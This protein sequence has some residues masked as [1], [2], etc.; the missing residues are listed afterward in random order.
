MITSDLEKA[1]R[2]AANIKSIYSHSNFKEEEI[3]KDLKE[4]DESIGDPTAVKL[5]VLQA[6][7]WLGVHVQN[8][9][10][11]YEISEINLPDFLK[12]YL[13]N[14]I[15]TN[16]L[17][18]FES[19]TPAKYQYLGRNHRF[20]EQLCQLILA[21][22]FEQR[23]GFGKV[24]RTSVIRTNSVDALTVLVQFRV[25]NVIKEVKGKNE[26]IA[27]EMYLWGYKP[28][29]GK[30]EELSF[31][32]SK[33]LLNEAQTVENIHPEDQKKFLSDVLNE[34]KGLE[35]NFLALAENRAK[36]LV[37]A[38]S[39]FKQYVGN[40]RYEAVH[41]VLPPDVL[42]MYVLVPNPENL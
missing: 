38:H 17:V 36:H 1:K 12:V 25:R 40:K 10:I 8:N 9:Q 20:V 14:K 42:G 4:V 27:E 5:F 30:I 24:A 2:K 13:K 7:E 28:R 39:R 37:E 16:Y 6:M 32:E 19:P 18:S 22:S 23:K 35:K 41:P 15:K 3:K 11:G 21:L 34:Y 29:T 26:V 33:K 31:D